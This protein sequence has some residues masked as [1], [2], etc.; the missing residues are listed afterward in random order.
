MAEGTWQ[1]GRVVWREL[2]T[3]DVDGAERFYG[4]LL[5]WRFGAMGLGDGTPYPTIEAGGVPIGGL[6]RMTAGARS[7]ASWASYVSV[8]DIDGALHRASARGGSVVMGP[9]DVPGQG[10]VAMLAD[11]WGASLGLYHAATSDAPLP[12]EPAEGTFCW[13]TLVAPDRLAAAS[14][15][16]EVIGWTVG[17]A[18]GGGDAPI[19]TAGGR[20]VADVQAASTGAQRAWFTYVAVAAL[21]PVRDRVARL[22]GAVHVPELRVPAVG[23]VAFVADPH[24]AAF[25]LLERGA[26]RRG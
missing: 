14:F 25:G 15:Y 20:P 1:T 9:L 11:P 22:G 19:L 12:D 26:R 16:A 10:R 18:P 5:G 17:P 3:A 23:R 7:P 2:L 21:E 13:E 4:E 8:P 6:A 24:G